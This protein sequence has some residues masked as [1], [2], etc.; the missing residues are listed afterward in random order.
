MRTVEVDRVILSAVWERLADPES[1]V[2]TVRQDCLALLE[3]YVFA[4]DD[5]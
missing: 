5:A 2:S 4:K 1:D 3:P